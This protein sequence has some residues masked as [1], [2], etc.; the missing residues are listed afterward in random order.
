MRNNLLEDLDC[1][2][3]RDCIDNEF[4]LEVLNLVE[5]RKTLSIIEEPHPAGINFI[6]GA[7]MI[8]G[9]DIRKEASHLAG[10]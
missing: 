10:T 5:R 3:Q 2:L 4:G 9:K 1:V 6:D 8:E 7:F